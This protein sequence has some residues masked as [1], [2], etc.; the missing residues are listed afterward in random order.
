MKHL[1]KG[2]LGYRKEEHDRLKQKNETEQDGAIR[3]IR[4]QRKKENNV[5]KQRKETPEQRSDRLQNMQDYRKIKQKNETKEE[6]AIRL[7]Q[8]KKGYKKCESIS[9]LILTFHDL[10]AVGPTS[11][12][13]CC[14]QLWYKHSVETI[15]SLQKVKNNAV[16]IC[17]PNL[18][19]LSVNT[20]ICMTC[21]QNLNKDKV[22]RCAVKNK[23]A[24]PAAP[25][26]LDLTDLEWRLVSP[27][28]IF[29]K[30]QQAPRGKQYNI[31]GNVVNVPADVINTVNVLPRLDSET[32]TVKVHLKRRL[33][34]KN[35]T[36][37]Q[38]VRPL[39][40]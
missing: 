19:S 17:I 33:K 6:R 18:N 13:I 39:K 26:N 20:C 8:R 31:S 16:K 32:G 2:A 12:C 35:C 15:T 9:D 4:Q 30:I 11:V 40:A 3:A 1:S 5:I 24:F 28:L 23:I 27:R 7:V 25:Q 14:D 36:M 37:S 22:P 38:N 34:Y 21:S 29:Q 10:V